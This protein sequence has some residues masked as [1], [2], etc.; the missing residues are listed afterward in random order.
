MRNFRT[1]HV[2]QD[3]IDLVTRVYK[4]TKHLPPEEIYSLTKQLKRSAISIPSNFA[5]GC[6]RESEKE[7]KHFIEVALGSAFELETQL[8][9]ADNLFAV[10]TVPLYEE[11]F[12]LLGKIQAKLN[13][14]RNR[15]K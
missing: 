12:Q 3:S 8:I 5:E 2:W 1:Y 14:F 7:F 11:L 6:S 4:L 15:L 10:K 9:I 13:A